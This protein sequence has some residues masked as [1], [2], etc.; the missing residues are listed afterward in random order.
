MAELNSTRD[1]TKDSAAPAPEAS[2][3]TDLVTRPA[4][5]SEKVAEPAPVPDLGAPELYIHRELSQLQFNIRVLEQA[6]D[7]SYP[8]LERLKFLLI[9]SSNL[10]EFFEIR[11]A[12]LKKQITFAREQT[13]PD[14]LQPQQVLSKISETA[15]YQVS[16]QYS[17]LND[18]LLP[19]LNEKGI[20][21]LRRYQWTH[22]QTLW[23]RRFFRQQVAP[24]ISP[25][26]LDPT[27]PF[28]LLVNKSLNFIVQ[29]DGIDSFGR[30]SGMAIIPAPRSLPRLIRL[31]DELCDGGDNFVFL[32]S[33]IHA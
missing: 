29:L 17:I 6:L 26:G 28:P 7:E 31:P 9:F 16:R 20:R 25:I 15:H 27:H 23:I 2:P 18:I 12:G 32:S 19:Q 33:M 8:L 10:D 5:V 13:G 3:R 11:V 30:D 21:F 24:I 14:G 4:Q 22:K 1:T